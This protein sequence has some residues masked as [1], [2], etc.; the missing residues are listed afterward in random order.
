[1][2]TVA[3]APGAETASGAEVT[4]FADINSWFK[5]G[6]LSTP[7][8]SAEA[9]LSAPQAFICGVRSIN[10]FSQ[11]IRSKPNSVYF[12]YN[13]VTNIHIPYTFIIINVNTVYQYV[14]MMLEDEPLYGQC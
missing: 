3:L 8:A 12:I 13:L 1:V 11:L 14:K 7:Y 2:Y 6:G 5:A 10:S 9:E 4:H